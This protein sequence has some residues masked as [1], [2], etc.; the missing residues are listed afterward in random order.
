MPSIDVEFNLS[1][2]IVKRLN[3]IVSTLKLPYVFVLE[4]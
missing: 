4:K 3:T 1:H 2:D